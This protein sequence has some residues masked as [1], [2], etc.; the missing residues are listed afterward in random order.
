MATQEP[1]YVS[2]AKRKQADL[3][4][5]IP[6]EWTLP[7]DKIPPGMLSPADSIFEGPKYYGPVRVL[8]IPRT[9]GI[10]L[11]KELIITEKYGVRGLVS[12]MTSAKFT[13]EEVVRA[14]SKAWFY[15]IFIFQRFSLTCSKE[16]CHCSSAYTLF[17]RA[18]FRSRFETR[19]RA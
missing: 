16:S 5:A 6:A 3:A 1:P 12:A 17:N 13:A 18:S 19:Q 7:A 11:E 8:D 4:A 10:L 2:I 15:S 9:C 14:F